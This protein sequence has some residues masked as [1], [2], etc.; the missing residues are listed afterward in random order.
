MILAALSCRLLGNAASQ[1]KIRRKRYSC[2]SVTVSLGRDGNAEWRINSKKKKKEEE[3]TKTNM[4][5]LQ[6]SEIFL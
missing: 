3:N 2:C 4:K 1:N 6:Q 5:F